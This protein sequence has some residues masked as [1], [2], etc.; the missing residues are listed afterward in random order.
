MLSI[1][2]TSAA[3]PPLPDN[4]RRLSLSWPTQSLVP[5]AICF[6]SCFF[7]SLSPPL[8][9]FQFVSPY[10]Q[11]LLQSPSTSSA[12][13][14][15]ELGTCIPFRYLHLVNPGLTCRAM[16][17]PGILGTEPRLFEENGE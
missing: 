17:K 3:T 4:R 14:H 1:R 10:R 2:V 9:V 13:T 11:A 5:R 16:A 8:P 12:L 15:L 6:T 7:F